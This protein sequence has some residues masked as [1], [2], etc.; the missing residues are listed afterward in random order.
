[1]NLTPEMTELVS[2]YLSVR[3]RTAR[4]IWI[5]ADEDPAIVRKALQRLVSEG[6]ATRV[7]HL[8]SSA[9]YAVSG[10]LRPHPESAR[11]RQKQGRQQP[12][13]KIVDDSA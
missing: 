10:G 12:R 1:M 6:R 9:L 7:P 8:R 5:A 2:A 11:Q 3:L 4:E 13:P